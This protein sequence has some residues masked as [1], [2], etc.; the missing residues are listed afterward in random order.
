MGGKTIRIFEESGNF[1]ELFSQPDKLSSQADKAI[2][3]RK[4][5]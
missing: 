3:E 4:H 1:N 5:G 2:F